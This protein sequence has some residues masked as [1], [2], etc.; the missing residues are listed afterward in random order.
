MSRQRFVIMSV[1]GASTVAANVRS[2]GNEQTTG[3]TLAQ[4]LVLIATYQ[5]QLALH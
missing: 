5:V 1:G 2:C 4:D 3:P